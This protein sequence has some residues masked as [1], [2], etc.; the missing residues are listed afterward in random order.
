MKIGRVNLAEVAGTIIADLSMSEPDR[1]VEVL[2]EP[3][4][5]VEGDLPLLRILLENLIGNAWKF[6]SKTPKAKIQIEGF[7]DE[8]GRNGCAVKDNGVGFDMRY[9][10]KLF[11]A[12]QRLHSETEFPGT[13]IGLATVLRIVRRHGGDVQA[14]SEINIGTTFSFV[15][16]PGREK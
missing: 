3:E 10:N 12:F 8:L 14:E 2:I 13:G 16:G 11:G 7:I 6:S 9:C 15:L 1:V 5:Y 4:I